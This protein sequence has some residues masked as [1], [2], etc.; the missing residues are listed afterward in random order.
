MKAIRAITCVLG[1]A[2]VL[3]GSTVNADLSNGGFETTDLTGWT[4]TGTV[5]AVTFEMSRDFI[6]PIAP[7][8]T[9]TEGSYFA[10]LL[11]TGWAGDT[12]MLSRTFTTP[13]DGWVLEFDYFFHF[14]SDWMDPDTAT[15]TL[16]SS[17]GRSERWGKPPRCVKPCSSFGAAQSLP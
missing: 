7:D 5:Q 17:S 4:A 15:A 6:F 14:G 10:S 16:T 9:P 3:C 8:W 12:A 2:V 1:I 11:S 13:E